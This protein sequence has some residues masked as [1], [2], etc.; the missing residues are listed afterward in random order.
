MIE[1]LAYSCVFYIKK[2]DTVP[3][4]LVPI[5]TTII[6]QGLDNK[7]ITKFVNRYKLHAVPEKGE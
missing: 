7:D 5:T 3:G 6:G 1:H 2:T 4:A